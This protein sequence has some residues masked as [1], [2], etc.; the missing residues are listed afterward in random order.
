MDKKTP[1]KKRA[2]TKGIK[3]VIIC[4]GVLLVL[5]GALY[6]ASALLK[7]DKI[8]FTK[9]EESIY[10]FPADYDEDPLTDLVYVSKNREIMFMDNAGNGEPLT[11]KDAE[12]GGVRALMYKYFT[13]LMTGDA[14]SHSNL[15]TKEYKSNF[16]VQKRFTAQKVYDINISFLTGDSDGGKYLEKYQVSYRIYENNG[17]YRADVGSNIAKIMVFEVATQNGNALINSIVPMNSK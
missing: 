16:V 10:F 2:L 13:A 4:F 8:D 6:G 15:L 17:T 7:G 12:T 14:E 9:N 3:I 1:D 11:D 5:L